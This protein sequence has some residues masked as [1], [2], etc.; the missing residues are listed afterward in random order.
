VEHVLNVNEALGSNLR[1]KKEFTYQ[2]II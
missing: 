1:R 2:K